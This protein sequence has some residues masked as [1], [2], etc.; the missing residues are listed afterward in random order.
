[1]RITL[2]GG[3]AEKGRTCVGV[4]SGGYR[5]LLDAGIMTSARATGDYYPAVSADVLRSVDATLITHAHEDHVGALG[6]CV[7]HGLAGPIY[8]TAETLRESSTCLA[9][10]A[11][12]AHG[13][14]VRHADVVA[15][16]VG[17][18]VLQ[19]GPLRIS[20]GRSGHV[21]GGVWCAI[22]DGEST[23]VYCGDVAP[24][25]PVFAMDAPPRCRT[26]I[27]DASY[28][29]DD[30]SG[31]LRASEIA[32]WIGAH[33]QGC[34]L[35]TPLYGQSA[36][37]LALVP[38]P[39]ALA[40]RMRD[41]LDAQIRADEWLGNGLPQAL[42]ERLDAAADWNGGELPRATLLCHDGMGLSGTSPA[43]LGA[44]AARSHPMLF[45][46]HL[47]DGSPGDRLVA[48]GRADWIRLP[49]HPTRTENVALAS[50]TGAGVVIGHSC[51]ASA[52]RAL[53][54]YLPQLMDNL[55]T[56]DTVD[57]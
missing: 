52:L 44:A 18:D 57:V 20:T 12:P 7:A 24:N 10:Y 31:R 45:T 28:G 23:L 33:P 50:A 5:L 40:Q 34:V 26:L 51:T 4:E 22:D 25:S 17:R 54:Q 37:L 30:V 36:E 2:H 16:P 55:A 13:A 39:I 48:A 11:E 49:T 27:L 46:G 32:A 14:L 29:A 56:G 38:G 6:W 47:P 3:F 9:D 35:A 21:S 8:M 42:R 53:A 1:M 43:I 19:A 15:L 41:A